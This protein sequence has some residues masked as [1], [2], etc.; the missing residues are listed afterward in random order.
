MQHPSDKDDVHFHIVACWFDGMRRSVPECTTFMYDAM[1][2]EDDKKQQKGPYW[3]ATDTATNSVI[4]VKPRKDRG[5]LA[6]LYDQGNQICQVRVEGF[7]D[8][9]KEGD[10]ASKWVGHW[11]RP[12][13]W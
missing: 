13:Q 9:L 6:R 8:G 7:K 11:N 2:K 12:G 5:M 10:Q 4:S 3:S 1:M